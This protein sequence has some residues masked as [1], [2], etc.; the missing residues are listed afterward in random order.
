MS[1]PGSEINDEEVYLCF[2]IHGRDLAGPD[3]RAASDPGS[4]PTASATIDAG[5]KPDES[6]HAEFS[7]RRSNQEQEGQPKE[8]ETEQHG[9]SKLDRSAETQAIEL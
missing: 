1:R 7:G 5:P 8:E 9:R 2:P 6:E 4:N 3:Q